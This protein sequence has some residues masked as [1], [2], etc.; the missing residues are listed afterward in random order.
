MYEAIPKIIHARRLLKAKLHRDPTI[1]EIAALTEY[2]PEKVTLAIAANQRPQ[3]A[4]QVGRYGGGGEEQEP[5]ETLLV[6]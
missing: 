4:E 6:R 5:Q 1:Q 2:A 3:S